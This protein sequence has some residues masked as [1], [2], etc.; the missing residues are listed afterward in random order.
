MRS[1]REAKKLQFATR[2]S[3]DER[4][5]K[6]TDAL[7]HC[8]RLAWRATTGDDRAQPGLSRKPPLK[9]Q[10]LAILMS[11]LYASVLLKHSQRVLDH[12]SSIMATRELLERLRGAPTCCA[13]SRVSRGTS[14]YL[15]EVCVSNYGWLMSENTTAAFVMRLSDGENS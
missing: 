13:L 3:D 4:K 10:P 11:S 8:R 7:T 2:S 14:S 12:A 9:T 6:R 5:D 15:L 1:F